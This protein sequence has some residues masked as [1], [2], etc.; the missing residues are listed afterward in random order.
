MNNGIYPL[1]NIQTAMEN[2]ENHYVSFW[3]NQLFQCAIFNSKL[4]V[5]PRVMLRLGI[6][7]HIFIYYCYPDVV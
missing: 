2:M 3:G 5:Y 1:V 6:E 4:L 7:K